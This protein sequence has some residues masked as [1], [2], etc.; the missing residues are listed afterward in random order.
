MNLVR[1]GRIVGK[2][3]QIIDRGSVGIK[4]DLQFEKTR[5]EGLRVNFCLAAPQ[6]QCGDDGQ[7]ALAEETMFNGELR[8]IHKLIGLCFLN[9]RRSW[10]LG[11]RKNCFVSCSF[12]SISCF[13]PGMQVSSGKFGRFID[14]LFPSYQQLSGQYS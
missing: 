9:H 1:Q 14:G 10:R 2:C 4:I 3:P 11:V 7:S 6:R 5:T 12:Q 13:R 8:S